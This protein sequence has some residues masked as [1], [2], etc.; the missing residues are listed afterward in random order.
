MQMQV[1]YNVIIVVGSPLP[2]CYDPFCSK[3]APSLP[4]SYIVTPFLLFR[5]LDNLIE[6]YNVWALL[7]FIAG[8]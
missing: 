8:V 5:H 4:L 6:N 7:R 1:I 3:R 2:M